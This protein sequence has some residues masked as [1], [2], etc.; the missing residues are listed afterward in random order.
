MQAKVIAPETTSRAEFTIL[1][2]VTAGLSDVTD[3]FKHLPGH[4]RHYAAKSEYLFKLLQPLVDDLLFIGPEYE[5]IFDTFEVLYALEHADHYSTEFHRV[6]GP[7]GRFGWKLWRE[8]NSSP[9][10]RVLHEAEQQGA[11]WAPVK[12]GLFGGSIDRFKEIS[13]KYKDYV[14]NLNWD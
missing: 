2:A 14:S 10:H 7:P 6:W 11:S 8:D 3:S 4:E 5:A 13:S 12:A 1:Y 9:L